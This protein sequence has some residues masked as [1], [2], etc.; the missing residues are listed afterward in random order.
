LWER[1]CLEFFLGGKPLKL[2]VLD[3]CG[4]NASFVLADTRSPSYALMTLEGRSASERLLP[5][6]RAAL[7]IQGWMLRDLAAVGVVSGPGSFTGARVGLAAAKGFCEAAV[8]PLVMVSRL[9]VLAHKAG[10]DQPETVHALLS[11]GRGEFFYRRSA[12]TK[13]PIEALLSRD[14]VLAATIAGIV[15]ACE[16]KIRQEFPERNVLL[17]PP[18]TASDALPLVLS[19]FREQTFDD[20]ASADANYLG[21]T[22]LEV[23]EELRRR[24]GTA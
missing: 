1:F 24:A 7:D 23:L 21:R 20:I 9:A 6:L 8:L 10:A 2:F 5:E 12:P 17:T 3:P 13:L 22:E 18:L 16:P 14:A 4:A 11:A 19:R 15:V